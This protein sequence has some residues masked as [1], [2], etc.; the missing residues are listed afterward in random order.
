METGNHGNPVAAGLSSLISIT[1][2]TL[3]VISLQQAQSWLT[4]FGSGVA[5]VSGF[6]AIRYYYHATKKIK[7]GNDKKMVQ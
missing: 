1:S 7:N 2:A 6:F 5:V 3:S 4:L